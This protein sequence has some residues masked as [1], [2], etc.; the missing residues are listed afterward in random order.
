MWDGDAKNDVLCYVLPWH[1]F[2]ALKWEV[3]APNPPA[4]RDPFLGTNSSLTTHEGWLSSRR[5]ESLCSFPTFAASCLC[6]FASEAA[7]PRCLDDENETAGDDAWRSITTAA[8]WIRIICCLRL[9]MKG[10]D[11]KQPLHLGEKRIRW[12]ISRDTWNI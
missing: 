11:W 1:T 6:S 4:A 5:S 12:I 9:E 10:Y 3:T 2:A 7:P 8:W